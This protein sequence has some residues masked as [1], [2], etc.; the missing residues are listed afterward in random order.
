MKAPL[1]RQART[2]FGTSFDRMNRTLVFQKNDERIKE[3]NTG[4]I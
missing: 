3:S 1:H 4:N 2:K